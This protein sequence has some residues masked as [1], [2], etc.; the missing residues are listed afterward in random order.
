MFVKCFFIDLLI[1]VLFLRVETVTFIR[2][3]S[4]LIYGIM[5]IVLQILIFL[6]VIVDNHVYTSLTL[7][8]CL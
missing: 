3:I 1:V 2:L 8:V 6:C 4:V 5:L 7:G